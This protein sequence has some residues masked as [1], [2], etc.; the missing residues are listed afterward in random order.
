MI[1]RKHGVLPRKPLPHALAF[2][3]RVEN[4][5]RGCGRPS[6]TTQKI[7]DGPRGWSPF[8]LFPLGNFGDGEPKD[9]GVYDTKTKRTPGALP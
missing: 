4:P 3:P 5:R 8:P 9:L 2:G 6:Q 1:G 7:E